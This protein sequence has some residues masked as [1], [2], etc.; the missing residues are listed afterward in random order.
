MAKWNDF[1]L[2]P[3]ELSAPSTPQKIFKFGPGSIG[4]GILAVVL[5][6]LAF[7]VANAE[8]IGF[9]WRT[10]YWIAE[11]EDLL[12]LLSLVLLCLTPLIAAAGSVLGIIGIAR[13]YDRR[14][15]GIIGLILNAIILVAGTLFFISI[16]SHVKFVT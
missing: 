9:H 7:I 3:I 2:A 10:Q 1:H 14:V 6:A 15:A 16:L 8:N 13:K 11:N 5:F 4:L 12:K